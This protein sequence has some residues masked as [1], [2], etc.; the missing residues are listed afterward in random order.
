M[1]D[2]LEKPLESSTLLRALERA[3][4]RPDR[5]GGIL[6][7]DD[8]PGALR[9]MDATLA[10]LGFSTITRSTARC[11][12]RGCGELHPTAVVLDLVM[13]GMDGVEFLDRFRRLPEHVRTPVLI[14]TMKELT[15]AE[16][17][18]LRT[19]GAG[20]RVEERQHRR[21]RSSSS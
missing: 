19:V 13:D 7:V 14:W 18:R 10:Q 11:G 20:S 4:V 16:H 17:E 21:R 15:A 2:V 6:V 9:L 12:A 1:H 5:R 8:D 3:G